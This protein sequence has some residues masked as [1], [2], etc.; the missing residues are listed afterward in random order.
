VAVKTGDVLVL[1][2]ARGVLV[3]EILVLPIRRGPASEAQ[4]CYRVLD[5]TRLSTLAAAPSVSAE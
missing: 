4:A 3:I 2:T 1:P 5:E